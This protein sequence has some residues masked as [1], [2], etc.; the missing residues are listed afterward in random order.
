MTIDH[1]NAYNLYYE[2]RSA[3][4]A[5]DLHTAVEKFKQSL[6]L[7]PHFKALELLGECL[8]RRNEFPEAILYLAA[9]AGL[10]QKEFRAQ[11]LLAKALLA[12]GEEA[13]AIAQL[14]EALALNPNYKSAKELLDSLSAGKG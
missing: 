6:G 7:F 9:A 12:V 10:G 3:M 1:N 4:D 11:F 5:G 2:G 13:D 8:L 14:K